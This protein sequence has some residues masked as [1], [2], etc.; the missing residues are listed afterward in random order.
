MKTQKWT[1]VI[2]AGQRP[3]ADPLAS[4]FGGTVKA[5]VDLDGE[6]MITHV[7]R[8]LHQVP[9]ISDMIV[10]AQQPD[11]LED[12]VVAGGGARFAA[13]GKGI[14]SSIKAVAGG[15]APW[16]VF[17]TTADHPLLQPDWISTFLA[18]VG[19]ADVAVGM[20]EKKVMF[21][22][23]PDNERTWLKFRDGHWSGANLF[24]LTSERAQP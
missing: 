11:M 18:D 16:P 3:G 7:I 24:A 8:A 21:A 5:L 12:A 6:A 15:D 22:S 14:S 9:E 23:Y 19:D 17:V 13:S 2:L 10:L 20:V 4:H 1:A